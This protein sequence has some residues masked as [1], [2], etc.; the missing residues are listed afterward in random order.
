MLTSSVIQGSFPN[1]VVR[2]QPVQR[3]AAPAARPLPS[4]AAVPVP[5][6]LAPMR[7]AGQP[8]PAPVLQRMESLFGAKFSDVRVHV[9]ADAAKLGAQAFT[10]GSNIYFAPGHCRPER[11]ARRADAGA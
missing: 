10:Q 5:P 8:L 6:A 7:G 9:G 2:M 4:G 3:T 1:G 11:R